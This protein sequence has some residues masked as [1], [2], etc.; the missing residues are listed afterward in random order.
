MAIPREALKPEEAACRSSQ[1]VSAASLHTF[2]SFLRRY[3]V[4]SAGQDPTEDFPLLGG[5]VMMFGASAVQSG[6]ALSCVS[7]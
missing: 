7:T 1:R 6:L 3:H 5:G 4:E 2:P